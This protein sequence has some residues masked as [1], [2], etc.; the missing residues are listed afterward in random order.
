M[1]R[2][3][4]LRGRVLALS[5]A[6]AL[7][8]ALLLPAFMS[9]E[10]VSAAEQVNS[11][12]VTIDKSGTTETDVEYDFDFTLPSTGVIQGIR[13]QWCTT[14]LG[15]CTAVSGLDVSAM[16]VDAQT[17]SEATTFADNAGGDENDCT[18]S[19]NSTR[20][21]CLER[22]D[23][24]TE[25]A[26]AKSVT[27]SGITH[28]GVTANTTVYVRMAFYDNNT[29]TPGAGG[30]NIL[31]DGVVATAI[32][33]TLTIQARVQEN[34]MFCIGTT[35]VNDGTTN[36]GA[37]CTAISGTTVDIGVVDTTTTGAVSP[38]AEGNGLNGIAFLR[39][40]ANGGTTIGYRAVQQSGTNHQGALR[41]LGA[42][43]NAGDV[44]T[45]QCFDSLGGVQ[46]VLAANTE[47]FGMT[48]EFVN[49]GSGGTTTAVTRNASYDGSAG[50]YAW[51]EAGTLANV[52]NASGAV[53][54]EALILK[55]AAVA[56]ITTPTG[57]YQAQ[58]KFV[59]TPTF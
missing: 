58:A 33:Q 26:A 27:L 20:E 50:G 41:V 14:P 39:T 46:T 49:T 32:V 53:D 24:D 11:R 57:S 36:P 19:T 5:S 54:D 52:A 28:T 16:T 10:L 44:D 51:N 38:D 48:A 56:A 2:S 17:F 18:D 40:N 34:L 45:D 47:Q 31:F 55:F 12:S 9:P 29:F 4:V 8:L 3:S 22:T 59:A 13:L 23:T 6:V 15:T 37:D 43:C 21:V 42:T 30:V 25:T 7:A 1:T 35:T